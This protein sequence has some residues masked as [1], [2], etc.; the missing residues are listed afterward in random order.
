MQCTDRHNDNYLKSAAFYA[1]FEGT[2]SRAPDE[3][4]PYCW[5]SKPPMPVAPGGGGGEPSPPGEQPPEEEEEQELDLRVE[6]KHVSDK[7]Y[8]V[9]L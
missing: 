6:Y 2:D 8:Q 3:E 9:S 1:D 7:V 4:W 5:S